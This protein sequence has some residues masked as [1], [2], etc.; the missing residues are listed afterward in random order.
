M[1]DLSNQRLDYFGAAGPED[2][3][4]SLP[5]DAGATTI[6]VL[7]NDGASKKIESAANGTHGSVEVAASGDDLTYTP[8]ADFCGSD[9]FTYTLVGGSTATVT[10]TVT[11]APDAPALSGGGS[12]SYGENDGPV[13][14]SSG[15]T[16]ADPDG[17]S[18]SGASA[19]ITTGFA[20]GQD[21]LTCDRRHGGRHQPGRVGELRQ[22]DRA[23][24]CRDG[25]GSIR[26]RCGRFVT[27]TRARSRTRRSGR[28]RSPRPISTSRT[29]STAAT[30]TVGSVNDAPV[31]GD[32]SKSTDEDTPLTGSVPSSD[33]EGDAL[34]ATAVDE[35]AH[36]SLSL[37]SDGSYTYTPN[38][39][40]H[41]SDG[42]T[43]TVN[44]GTADSGEG[45]VSIT[46]NSVNDPPV[47]G[48][49][50]KSTGE[51]TPS[52]DRSRPRT[53]TV[54]RWRSPSARLRTGRWRRPQTARTL[55]ARTR[56]STA[57][58]HSPT[59]RTTGA[60]DSAAGT[61]TITVDQDT[62]GDGIANGTDTDD[63]G[64]GV[65]DSR[66]RL[67]VELRRVGRHGR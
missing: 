6:D 20:A 44:D 40:F 43:Y 45:T 13:V 57:P 16:V 11:C 49:D 29:G 51:D 55:H 22:R 9:T 56:T 30:I 50:S 67:P 42:F 53:P 28:S 60:A 24:G 14:V 12:L 10:V 4:A 1:I 58:T 33:A 41:G 64:D 62:D 35:P 8:N 65:A 21:K 17:D 46:V 48:D 47:A 34:T 63:D 37:S 7:A 15:L 36:G 25:C 61:V 19:E 39:D 54:T 18:I 38:A 27:R 66:G 31:A 3:A 5:E 2:D 23:D 32:D 52:R 59:R 26:R